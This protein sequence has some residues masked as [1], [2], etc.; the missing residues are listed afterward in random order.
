VRQH[1]RPEFLNRLDDIVVFEPLQ[2]EELLAI[3]DVQIEQVKKLLAQ[4]NLSIVVTQP[5]KEWLG[6]QG[7]DPVY[8]ARPLKRL[9]TE[10]LLNPLSMRLLEGKTKP[11]DSITIDL[12]SKKDLTFHTSGQK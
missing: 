4:R 6:K 10:R 5:A 1:F 8:G 7:Y 3:V 9:I 11:G 12:D 2:P